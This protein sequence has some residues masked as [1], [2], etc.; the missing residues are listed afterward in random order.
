MTPIQTD[1]A[2]IL[3]GGQRPRAGNALKATSWLSL[4]VGQI[5]VENPE[6]A[7]NALQRQHKKLVQGQTY[8]PNINVVLRI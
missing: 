6:I 3:T 1:L 2:P 8:S 4:F 7:L 5:A